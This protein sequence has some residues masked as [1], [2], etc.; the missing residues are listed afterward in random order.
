M[1]SASFI[2]VDISLHTRN[3]KGVLTLGEKKNPLYFTPSLRILD[4]NICSEE[5]HSFSI[6]GLF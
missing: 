3:I 5:V 6:T 4:A 1:F 2:F